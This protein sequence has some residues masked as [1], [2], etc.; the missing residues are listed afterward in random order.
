M[1][2]SA[3]WWHI[4][5]LY[6]S[7]ISCRRATI[8]AFIAK[9]FSHVQIVHPAVQRTDSPFR[10]CVQL[11]SK[12]IIRL[13][14]LSVRLTGIRSGIEKIYMQGNLPQIKL[15]CLLKAHEIREQG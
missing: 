3:T 11:L 10:N 8:K 12:W 7:L 2:L 13:I 1:R 4:L 9:L 6:D 15:L 5:S 14:C